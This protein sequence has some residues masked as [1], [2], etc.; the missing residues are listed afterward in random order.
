MTTHD[1]IEAHT[2]RRMVERARKVVVVC[3]S[4]KIGRAAL[5]APADELAALRANGI[6]VETV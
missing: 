2:D 1:E 4:S 6:E 5:S 3:D